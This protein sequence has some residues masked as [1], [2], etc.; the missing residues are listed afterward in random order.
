MIENEKGNLHGTRV[1][2]EKYLREN[3]WKNWDTC[4]SEEFVVYNIKLDLKIQGVRP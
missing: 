1:A 3:S 4:G 2:D